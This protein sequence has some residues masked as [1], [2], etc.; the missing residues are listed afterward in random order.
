MDF[1][2][3]ITNP[4]DTPYD[5]ILI[6]SSLMSCDIDSWEDALEPGAERVFEYTYELTEE[7]DVSV[8]T[9]DIIR[10]NSAVGLTT[11]L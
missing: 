3:I 6:D 7:D 8:T 4:N 1:K 9:G 2:L 11:E 10:C 5:P